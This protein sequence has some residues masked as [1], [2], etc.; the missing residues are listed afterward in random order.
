MTPTLD[1]IVVG[2]GPNGLAA[3]I[4]L[5]RAGR[6]VRIYEAA[7]HRRRGCPLRRA[8][9]ARVRPRPVLVGPPAE[10]GV[11]VLPLAR[12]RAPRARVGPPRGAG[13]ARATRR[14]G[15]WCS[16]ASSRGRHSTRRWAAT[17]TT[18]GGSSGRSPATWERLVPMLLSPV[19]RPPRHPL[20]HGPLRAAG[21]A[22]GR[23]P[24]PPGVPRARHPGAVRRY[25]RPL[26]AAARRAAERVVRARARAA[27]ARR[28]LAGR[29]WRER[30]DRRRARGR[31]AVARGRD[32]DAPPG[33]L[34]RPAA[35]GARRTCSTSRRARSSRSPAIA[36]R[37]RYRRRL[38][39][40]RYGPGVFKVD[41]A[42]DG[43]IPWADPATARAGDRPPRRPDA[44]DRRVRGGGGD[45]AGMP[46]RP[47]VL[48]VQPTIADPSRAPE[49][50]HVAWAYCHVPNGSTVDMTAAIEAQVERFAPGF[51]DRILARATKDAAAMEA[52]DAE[53]R[54]RRH[55]RW[56]RRLAAAALPARSFAGTRTRRPTGRSSCAR[57]PRHPAAASTG[58]VAGTRRGR[59]IG[60]LRRR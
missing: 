10:P 59:P 44:R 9:A 22:P 26:D 51:R 33:G 21:P 2:A 49:G 34:A 16:P 36:C 47:F 58:W 24:G 32:R 12:P 53:L 57:R 23:R 8:H 15:A 46:D 19:I 6:S 27:R 31:G 14:D 50:K 17:P 43:P 39:G 48:L 56:D 55:Q 35:R 11:A 3:A 13:R 18:G 41:W 1:A 38:E 28:R 4:E 40:F 20:A 30:G 5:A 29:A 52:Y 60:V 25:G 54:G 42:L 37:P 7:G 45:E